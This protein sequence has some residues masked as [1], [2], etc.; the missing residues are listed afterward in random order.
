MGHKLTEDELQLFNKKYNI[1]EHISIAKD[2]LFGTLKKRCENIKDK[3]KKYSYQVFIASPKSP[4]VSIKSDV[5]K[6][7]AK[8]LQEYYTNINIFIHTPYG[9]NLSNNE[10][11]P[12]Y[13]AKKFVDYGKKMN[14]RGAVIHVGKAKKLD[15]K[16]ARDIMFANM[17]DIMSEASPECPIILETPAGQGT[18]LLQEYEDFIGFYKETQVKEYKKI[19]DNIRLCLDTCHIFALGYSPEEYIK[20]VIRDV[21][22]KHI[23][24]VHYN[25]SKTPKKS[26]K[27][28]HA[29]LSDSENHIPIAEME[30]IAKLCNKHG[31]PMTIENCKN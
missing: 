14:M 20:N 7:V 13:Y 9:L 31:I 29:I 21:G 3:H 6:D 28:R 30:S 8:L 10:L 12:A 11:K 27:D 18:E 5:V 22:V 23:A 17:I 16:V 1:G 26:K 4:H 2:G 19:R 25:G 15:K 24:L